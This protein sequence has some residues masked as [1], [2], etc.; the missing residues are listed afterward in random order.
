MN[1]VNHLV[2]LTLF[3]IMLSLALSSPGHTKDF[4]KGGGSSIKKVF[5]GGGSSVKRVFKGGGRSVKGVFSGSGHR[6]S[7]ADSYD[8][9]PPPGHVRSSSSG[10]RPYPT[11]GGRYSSQDIDE[12]GYEE[13]EPIITDTRASHPVPVLGS[14]LTQDKNKKRRP[15]PKVNNDS[16]IEYLARQERR[17]QDQR[18]EQD[19]IIAGEHIYR[20]QQGVFHDLERI[21]AQRSRGASENTMSAED[22]FNSY[23]RNMR[24]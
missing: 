16:Y 5:K 9:A 12:R 1:T 15:K 19:R 21:E 7:S 22:A 14:Y 20:N 6:S 17:R 2:K 13:D 23:T 24:R 4:F 3:S 10:R 11:M 18:R 8:N